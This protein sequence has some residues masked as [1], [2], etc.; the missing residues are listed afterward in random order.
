MY[1]RTTLPG[2]P[3]AHADQFGSAASAAL[4]NDDFWSPVFMF[5]T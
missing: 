1:V 5:Q 3:G 2:Y 4:I